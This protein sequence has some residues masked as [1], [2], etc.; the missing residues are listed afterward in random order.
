MPFVI[1]KFMRDRGEAK[2]KVLNFVTEPF[3]HWHSKDRSEFSSKADAKYMMRLHG[4]SEHT[5]IWI[6]EVPA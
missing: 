3:P 5:P 2:D 4:F 1:Q 6:Q